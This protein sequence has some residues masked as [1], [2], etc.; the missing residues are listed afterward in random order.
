MKIGM[1]Y[2][3]PIMVCESIY[4]M[5]FCQMYSQGEKPPKIRK[6]VPRNKVPGNFWTSSPLKRQR[7]EAGIKG[8]LV[9]KVPGNLRSQ[10]FVFFLGRFFCPLFILASEHPFSPQG[11]GPL[12][13]RDSRILY[14][15]QSE[16]GMRVG[17]TITHKIITEPNFTI[18]Q[19]ILVIV[20][21]E[22]RTEM[23]LELLGLGKKCEHRITESLTEFLWE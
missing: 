19:L 5:T 10:E 22:Y 21:C 8:T 3:H 9:R 2:L 11:L 12:S 14:V 16:P 7:K 23:F 1:P 17:Y 20:F 6:K 13:L 18:F 15:A 4:V